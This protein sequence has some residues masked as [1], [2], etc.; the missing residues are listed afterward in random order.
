MRTIV[1]L[2][3][4]QIEALDVFCRKEKISRA[5][6]VRRAVARFLPEDAIS[7]RDHPAVGLWKKRRIDSREYVRRLRKEWDR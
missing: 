7:W 6:A 5:E 2:P 4:D 3:D 1:D